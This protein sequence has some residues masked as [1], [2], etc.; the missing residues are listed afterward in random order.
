MK[1]T[2]LTHLLIILA[3]FFVALGAALNLWFYSVAGMAV[4]LYVTWRFFAFQSFA[5]MLELDVKRSVDKTVVQRGGHV[6]V[7]VSVAAARPVEGVYT[8][9]LPSGV[10]LAE[11]TNRVHLS[12]R[13]GRAFAWR[14]VF[15]AASREAVEIERATLTVDNGLF[16]DTIPFQTVGYQ[17]KQSP[18]AVSVEGGTGG[19]G[20]PGITSTSLEALYRERSASAGLELS[21]L[22]PFVVGDPLKNI[23]WKASARLNKLMTKE[24]FSEMEGAIGSGTNVAL[25]VDQSGTMG[26]GLPGA[27]ELDFAVNVAGNF[28]KLAVAKGSRIGLTT[29]NDNAVTTN[30]ETGSS[31]SH[32]SSVVRSLNEIE[33]SAP[34]RRPR[35]KLDVSGHDVIRIKKQ[36]AATPD[37]AIDDDIRY[38]R[39]VISYMY[40]Y[41]EGYVRTLKRS[42]A[43]RAVASALA[44]AYGQSTIV[45]VSDLENDLGPLTE[46]IRIATKRGAHVYVLALFSKVFEQF[47][48]PLFALEDIYA[49]Y[50]DFTMRTRKLEQIA[51]VTVIEANSPET[52]QPALKEA[53]IA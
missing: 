15:I 40:A 25:I 50:D 26:R 34:S 51:G 7:D 9:V 36:F 33:P 12:L 5:S 27:T 31:L 28:V 11:G 10:E 1:A 13:A 2:Q 30:L 21:H 29:Y 46:G 37:E 16:R 8:D 53:G 47:Q 39:H 6:A 41:S 23:H 38:F 42:P 24:F 45:L 19:T 17:I 22:R 48:D 35:R 49:A 18:Y 44:H 4:A 43:F 52:L 32:V 20:A 3:A 14:Y